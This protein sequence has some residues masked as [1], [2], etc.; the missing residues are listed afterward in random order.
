[1]RIGLI[2]N[3]DLTMSDK[4]LSLYPGEGDNTEINKENLVQEGRC[5][6]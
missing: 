5:N 2:W 6:L 1:M 4:D 3:L